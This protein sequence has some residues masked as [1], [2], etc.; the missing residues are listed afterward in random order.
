MD[1][2]PVTGNI[3]SQS[4][5]GVYCGGAGSQLQ[6]SSSDVNDNVAAS[7]GGGI[8]VMGGTSGWVN[9]TTIARNTANRGGGAFLE[10][11]SASIRSPT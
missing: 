3:A 9:T 1:G 4:G 8:A 6:V 7:F 2:V 5:G 11:V 10:G